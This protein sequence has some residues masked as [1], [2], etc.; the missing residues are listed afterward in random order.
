MTM[1]RKLLLTAIVAGIWASASLPT[2]IHPAKAD[3]AMSDSERI[4]ALW[5]ADRGFYNS[6]DFEANFNDLIVAGEYVHNNDPTHKLYYEGWILGAYFGMEYANY[7]LVQH[8]QKPLFCVPQ[9]LVLT[10][11]QVISIVDNF[12][13]HNKEHYPPAYSM[14]QFTGDAF[15][16]LFPCPA[17]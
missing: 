5:D 16:E 15:V 6:K 14:D 12:I 17:N 7:L 4:K 2:S 3:E 8:N 1:F 11:D 13:S 9:K 10:K